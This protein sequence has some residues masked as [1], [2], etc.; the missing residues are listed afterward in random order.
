MYGV[1]FAGFMNCHPIAMNRMTIATLVITIRPL[2]IADS[3]M[4]RISS[5][6]NISTMNAA[7]MFTIPCSRTPVAL[8]SS[9]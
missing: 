2:T 3:R 5:S 6:V 4:P 1:W 9:L 8:L 7:G